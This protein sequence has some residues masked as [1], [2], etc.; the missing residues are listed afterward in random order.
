MLD[1]KTELF[2]DQRTTQNSDQL[3]IGTPH[4]TMKEDQMMD[5]DRKQSN[6][7]SLGGLAHCLFDNEFF[8]I[9]FLELRILRTPWS[10]TR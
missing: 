10:P 8:C 2:S 7:Y 1:I 6:L 5:P 9:N 4:H 3:S